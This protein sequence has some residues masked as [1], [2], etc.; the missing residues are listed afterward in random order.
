M[1]YQKKWTVLDYF[2][3]LP[4]EKV[5]FHFDMMTIN[6]SRQL[7]VLENFKNKSAMDDVQSQIPRPMSCEYICLEKNLL[8]RV[9]N[10]VQQFL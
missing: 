10:N 9:L 4:F 2:L 3:S 5:V 7:K 8:G 6:H 1:L